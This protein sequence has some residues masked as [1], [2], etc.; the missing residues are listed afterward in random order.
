MK[1]KCLRCPTSLS[2]FPFIAFIFYSFLFLKER[3]SPSLLIM[4][5]CLPVSCL[6]LDCLPQRAL[7]CLPSPPSSLRPQGSLLL[8]CPTSWSGWAWSPSLWSGCRSCTEWRRRNPRSTRPNVTSANSVRSKVSGRRRCVVSTHRLP[9][10]RL[11][12]NRTEV[13]KKIDPLWLDANILKLHAV[14]CCT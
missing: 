13:V 7:L 12:T 9:A 10:G 3:L 8:R 4:C 5:P 6:Y 14:F 11:D 2:L 1:R